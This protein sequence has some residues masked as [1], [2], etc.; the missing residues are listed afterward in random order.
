LYWILRGEGLL[1][2]I[3]TIVLAKTVAAVLALIVVHRSGG[4]LRGPLERPGLR[5]LATVRPPFGGAAQNPAPR[6][7]VLLLS[8]LTTFA[9]LGLYSAASKVAELL[10]MFPMAFYLAMLPR[11]A[12][13]LAQKTA[14]RIAQWN[15]ALAW[16]FAAV[17]PV[18]IG[19]IGLSEPILRFVYGDAFVLATPVLRLQT[20]AFLLTT[21][22]AMLMM[23]CRAGGAQ[24]AD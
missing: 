10:L 6:L 22:D 7:D 3:A 20:V 12:G 15:R 21:V 9:V 14:P 2:I 16:Y 8:Q 11:V 13:D 24:R 23:I 17:I 19:A 1:A 18:G 4:R 5:P